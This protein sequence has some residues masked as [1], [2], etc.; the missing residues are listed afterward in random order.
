MRRIIAAALAASIGM[1]SPASGHDCGMASPPAGATLLGTGTTI[2]PVRLDRGP[3]AGIRARAELVIE[4]L[5]FDAP[6]RVMYQVSLQAPNGRRAPV[7]LIS[8]YTETAPGYGGGGGG[9]GG[10]G[11][12]RTFDATEALRS[13]G[14]TANAL[15]FEPTS[16]VTGPGEQVR[17]DPAA[18]VRFASASLRWR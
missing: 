11:S 12:R 13:L 7:G 8:F 15:V 3:R 17:V 14:G 5:A 18:R 10:G 6:P 9:G 4:G 2:V 16:G 1:A